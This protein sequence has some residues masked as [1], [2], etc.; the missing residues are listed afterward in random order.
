MEITQQV[1][2]YAREHG[3]GEEEALEA[4]LMEKA[5]QFKAVAG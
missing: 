5:E 2:E 4:G 1:R 3:M